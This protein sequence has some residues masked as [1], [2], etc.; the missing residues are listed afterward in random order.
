[1]E[2]I[3]TTRNYNYFKNCLLSL[4]HDNFNI[5]IQ[6]TFMK[7]KKVKKKFNFVQI[8]KLYKR[9]YK[10]KNKYLIRIQDWIYFNYQFYKNQK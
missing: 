3:R 9:G 1:M 4:Q 8:N 7:T 10:I 2:S 5:F 6:L